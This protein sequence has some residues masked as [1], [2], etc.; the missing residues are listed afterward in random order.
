[1]PQQE[2][3]EQI[4]S[5]SCIS[6]VARCSRTTHA[7]GTLTRGEEFHRIRQNPPFH[8][9]SNLLQRTISACGKVITF[10][11]RKRSRGQPS[12]PRCWLRL[13]LHTSVWYTLQNSNRDPKWH[14]LV[15]VLLTNVG[16]CFPCN[17]ATPLHVINIWE[18]SEPAIYIYIYINLKMYFYPANDN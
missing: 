13:R 12:M 7:R 16:D 2:A 10:G 17:K 3:T 6:E 14:A 8:K 4:K 11:R 9:S 1:M 18:A 15:I 5:L